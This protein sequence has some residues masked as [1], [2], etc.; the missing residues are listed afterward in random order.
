MSSLLGKLVKARAEGQMVLH[1]IG[2]IFEL[3]RIACIEW[4]AANEPGGKVM[5]L[6]CRVRRHL[7]LLASGAVG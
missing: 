7:S 4:L 2:E 3:E 6:T 5:G 1:A